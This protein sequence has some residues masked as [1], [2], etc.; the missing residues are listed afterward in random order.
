MYC[1]K[2]D[3]FQPVKL[4]SGHN[5]TYINLNM[6]S[7]AHFA[8]TNIMIMIE[9]SIQQS[10]R[11]P[12]HIHAR[13]KNFRGFPIDNNLYPKAGFADGQLSTNITTK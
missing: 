2:A 4:Q 7:P 3:S 10:Y 8:S 11:E 1:A 12:S 13:A 6:Y 5:A 9:L